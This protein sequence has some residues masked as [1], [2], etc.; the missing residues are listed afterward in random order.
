MDKEELVNALNYAQKQTATKGMP[1]LSD[2]QKV[3]DML[4]IDM[5]IERDSN[6]GAVMVVI[7]AELMKRMVSGDL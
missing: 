3:I 2:W 4:G 6:P 7:H 5:K 1:M